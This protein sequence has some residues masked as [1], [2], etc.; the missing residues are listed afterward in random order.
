MSYSQTTTS[1]PYAFSLWPDA[2]A[3]SEED[4]DDI[5]FDDLL[6]TTLAGRQSGTVETFGFVTGYQLD[7][8]RDSGRGHAQSRGPPPNRSE[9]FYDACT[10]NNHSSPHRQHGCIRARVFR[11]TTRKHMTD[12]WRFIL[13][14]ISLCRRT[15]LPGPK[16]SQISPRFH[17]LTAMVPGMDFLHSQ[18]L[19]P[20]PHASH[21]HHWRAPHFRSSTLGFG[22]LIKSLARRLLS[23]LGAATLDC[24]QTL[25]IP[26]ARTRT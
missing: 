11:H 2:S 15:S 22:I 23:S 25:S 17:R 12:S 6:D 10:A 3:A 9:Y 26:W 24:N 16:P 14:L 5:F 13:F 7:D 8:R 20:R 21:N 1:D 4:V 18:H 19:G